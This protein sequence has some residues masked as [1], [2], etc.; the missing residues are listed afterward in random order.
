MCILK[1]K[2]QL[3]ELDTPALLVDVGVMEKNLLWGQQKANSTGA[4]LKPHIKTHRTPA[5]AKKQ[6]KMRTKGITVTKLGEAEV[7]A[8]ED[9]DDIFIASEIIGKIKIE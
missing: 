3:Q 9:I 6:V 5:L 7:M 4:R 8:R 1:F 2:C